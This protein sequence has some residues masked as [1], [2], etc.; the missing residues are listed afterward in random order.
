M[1]QYKI[2]VVMS[3]AGN[4]PSGGAGIQADIEAIASMGAQAAPVITALT[5]QDTQNVQRVVP[6]EPTLVVEQARA[7]LEDMPVAA[8][9]I[10]LTGSVEIIEVIHSILHDYPDI[11]VVLDPI[12]R[13][14]GGTHLSGEEMQSAMRELLFPYATVLTPNSEEARALA[15]E[16]DTLDACAQELLD[17]GCELVLITGSH[18]NS[19]TV[20]NRLYGNHRLLET[21]SWDRLP[22]SYHGSGCTLASSIAGLLAQGLEPF[23][24]IHEA[25]EYT[26]E[27][28]KHGFRLGLGQHHPNRLFWARSEE[29]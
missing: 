17:G 7:V 2:P 12:L 19:E 6:V 15:H 28:L 21:F 5:V 26:W 11:P 27:S 4:D 14:G 18:E 9:K 8:F 20:D 13:A 24:A 22:H 16:A 25:Q 10:G 3:F 23:T 1:S 29:E